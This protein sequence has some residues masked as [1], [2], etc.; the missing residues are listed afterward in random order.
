M[1]FMIKLK[2]LLTVKGKLT[3]QIYEDRSTA[4]KEIKTQQLSFD[5][6]LTI[7]PEEEKLKVYCIEQGYIDPFLK[8]TTLSIIGTKYQGV[9][10]VY[11]LSHIP[12]E[13]GQLIYL[14]KL[15]LVNHNIK[16]LPS[17][18]EQLQN[19]TALNLARNSLSKIP[20]LSSL[21]GLISLNLSEQNT[22][23]FVGNDSPIFQL[24]KLER[25]FLKYNQLNRLGESIAKLQ[26]LK[27]L[28]LEGNRG[29]T[30]FPFSALKNLQELN[31][32]KTGIGLANLAKLCKTLADLPKLEILKVKA[33][34]SYY[35]LGQGIALPPEIGLLTSLKELALSMNYWTSLPPEI[36]KLK[37]LE[38][39]DL[40]D[41]GITHFSDEI[42]QLKKLKVLYWRPKITKRNG[43]RY[44]LERPPESIEKLKAL[45]PNTKLVF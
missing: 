38:K 23:L 17:E 31:L 5:Q 2:K 14:K 45:L 9:G 4:F 25:L 28:S 41:T 6:L 13:I 3:K 27:V 15:T 24:P 32:S 11:Q 43:R 34:R 35:E 18:I 16:I 10:K 39:L 19:L 8:A 33:I 21:K 42:G 29:F 44:D 12:A 40:F 20:V 1:L 36:G 22:G 26:H 37:S 30:K 7:V